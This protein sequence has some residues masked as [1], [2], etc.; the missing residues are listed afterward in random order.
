MK[1]SA[2]ISVAI[3]ALLAGSASAYTL[4]DSWN[5]SG[6]AGGGIYGYPANFAVKYIPAASYSC[7]KIEFWGAGS[8]YFDNDM[9]TV[10]IESDLLDQPSGEV[11]AEVQTPVADGD[12]Y[13]MGPTSRP[14]PRCR[15][16]SRTG[17]S[18]CPWPGH[19]SPGPRR[20]MS[21]RRCPL[22]TPSTGIR[23][24]PSDG[25]RSSGAIPSSPR[26]RRP[27]RTS[28]PC[29]SSIATA[30]ERGARC[31]FLAPGSVPPSQS[32]GWRHDHVTLDHHPRD[33][34]AHVRRRDGQGR[35]HRVRE[36]GLRKPDVSTRRLGDDHQ[37]PFLRLVSDRLPAP[38]R[39]VQRA[40]ALQSRRRRAGRV[41][42]HAGH[43]YR[44]RDVA[45][46][47]LLGIRA[48]LERALRR[49]PLRHGQHH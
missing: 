17:S 26:S 9:I 16:A 24:H 41:V 46:A 25:W 10:R 18:T 15:P 49:P 29:S 35:S 7:A 33:R 11:L 13:W 42:G 12:S 2:I 32:A 22:A 30:R 20:A 4:V 34:P 37:R 31:R 3:L 48:V 38:Y 8:D 47:H 21:S 40:G 28:R 36:R 44:W 43:E 6:T 5:E 23:R 14:R 1:H 19:R 45:R 39:R 27:G